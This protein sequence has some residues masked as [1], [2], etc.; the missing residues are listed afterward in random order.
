MPG[1]PRQAS[2]NETATATDFQHPVP[3]PDHERLQHAALDRLVQAARKGALGLG[4]EGMATEQF[5]YTDGLC[6]PWWNP[7]D[8]GVWEA[9]LPWAAACVLLSCAEDIPDEFFE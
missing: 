9:D 6:C 2:G 5:F 4:T 1:Q 8:G 3:R 7:W